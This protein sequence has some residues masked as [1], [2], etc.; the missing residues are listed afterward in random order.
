MERDRS[1]DLKALSGVVPDVGC[2]EG[3]ETRTVFCT[4]GATSDSVVDWITSTQPQRSR[5]KSHGN[6]V[7]NAHMS[8]GVPPDASLCKFLAQAHHGNVD[9]PGKTAR[10]LHGGMRLICSPAVAGLTRIVSV[11]GVALQLSTHM[12]MPD[13]TTDEEREHSV[14]DMGDALE[15][16]ADFE[17]LLEPQGRYAWP[18]GPAQASSINE[19]AALISRRAETM[20]LELHAADDAL[21]EASLPSSA[22]L[23]HIKFSKEDPTQFKLMTEGAHRLKLKMDMQWVLHTLSMETVVLSAYKVLWVAAAEQL[24]QWMV[25]HLTSWMAWHGMRSRQQVSEDTV[26]DAGQELLDF[27]QDD[28]LGGKTEASLRTVQRA[29]EMAARLGGRKNGSGVTRSSQ[30]TQE[31]QEQIFADRFRL[32]AYRHFVKS[33]LRYTEDSLLSYLVRANPADVVDPPRH[34]K[35]FDRSVFLT[36]FDQPLYPDQAFS[37]QGPLLSGLL[38]T[39]GSVRTMMQKVQQKKRLAEKGSDE[40]RIFNEGLRAVQRKYGQPHLALTHDTVT[41][42]DRPVTGIAP[43]SGE[44]FGMFAPRGTQKSL[45]WQRWALMSDSAVMSGAVA[46]YCASS[47]RDLLRQSLKNV[48]VPEQGDGVAVNVDYSDT[49]EHDSLMRE[50]AKTLRSVMRMMN[51]SLPSRSDGSASMITS[52]EDVVFRVGPTVLA[53]PKTHSKHKRRLHRVLSASVPL[54]AIMD[55]LGYREATAEESEALRATLEEILVKTDGEANE[56]AVD[57]YEVIEAVAGG[58]DWN[59]L[60]SRFRLSTDQ[61]EAVLRE[62]LSIDTK[63]GFFERVK[64]RA[65][66]L[67]RYPFAYLVSPRLQSV[68]SASRR[69][70]ATVWK[71]VEKGKSLVGLQKRIDVVD[72][73]QEPDWSDVEYRFAAAQEAWATR[74]LVLLPEALVAFLMEDYEDDGPVSSHRA[75]QTATLALHGTLVVPRV[76]A[77]GENDDWT[78][79][80]HR[81]DLSYSWRWSGAQSVRTGPSEREDPL[82]QLDESLRAKVKWLWSMWDGG[83]NDVA[84]NA[85]VGRRS[86]DHDKHDGQVVEELMLLR[87]SAEGHDFY[88]KGQEQICTY[89]ALEHVDLIYGTHLRFGGITQE[90]GDVDEMLWLREMRRPDKEAGGEA[91]EPSKEEEERRVTWKSPVHH[92]IGRY[93]LVVDHE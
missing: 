25:D 36:G 80:S 27:L 3:S 83:G 88:D 59:D 73:D 38:D 5:S 51:K 52:M 54:W 66:N 70:K 16:L 92:R 49:I 13:G 56:P 11:D 40:R 42:A 63:R 1:F 72:P 39:P 26:V 8:S 85:A 2:V 64:N 7:L 65:Y 86:K 22:A 91:E 90:R 55:M 61:T 77:A 10:P 45:A 35:D 82:N 89:A 50:V 84:L 41:R 18:G 43:H 4:T 71:A 81:D 24:G 68:R 19:V 58:A 44:P 32:D 78:D 21:K 33:V 29:Q 76:A 48:P 6:V 75:H 23:A 60:H 17:P 46:T 47:A 28:V 37:L 74:Y 31:E 30:L 93:K 79:N 67:R 14:K 69:V 87:G 62:M 57:P 34:T 15:R 12:V 20:Q 9:F 53:L